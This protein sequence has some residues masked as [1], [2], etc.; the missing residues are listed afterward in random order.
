VRELLEKHDMVD[1]KPSCLPM[2]HGFLDA[3]S[4]QTHVP[5]TGTDLAIYP[6]LLDT[7]HYA[8]V[9]TRLDISTALSIPGSAHANPT[10]AHMHALKKVLR[11]LKG[12][13]T[14]S[15]TLGG[16]NNSFQLTGFVDADWGNDNETRRSRSGFLFT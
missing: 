1:C 8:A 11:Y 7:L 3:I 15:L 6:S 12:S 13:P 10:V 16:T 2:D 4:K 9:C 5:L 14:M